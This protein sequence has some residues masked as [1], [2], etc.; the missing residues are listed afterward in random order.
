[1]RPGCTWREMESDRGRGVTES[2]E[3]LGT[4]PELGR[5]GWGQHW[6]VHN[7]TTPQN[8]GMQVPKESAEVRGEDPEGGDE[9]RTRCGDGQS[10]APSWASA[11]LHGAWAGGRCPLEALEPGQEGLGSILP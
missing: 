11:V 6:G 2:G 9:G 5:E 10:G 7:Q 4:G 3:E 1:M 8:L